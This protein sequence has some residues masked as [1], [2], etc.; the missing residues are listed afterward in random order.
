MPS[1]MELVERVNKGEM[2]DPSLLET[3]LES[4]NSAEKFLAHHARAMLDLRGAHQHMLQSLQAIDYADQKVLNQFV[5]IAGFLGMGD[6]RADPIVKFAASAISR[7]EYALGIEA[8]QNALT[9]DQQHG[10]AWTS[11]RE[12]CL[13]AAGLFERAACA[14][15]WRPETPTDW[16]NKQLRIGWIVSSIADDDVCSRSILSFARHHDSKKCRVHVYSTEALVR[17][18]RQHFA[19]TAYT[20]P[21]AKRGA[22]TL[23]MLGRMKVPCWTAPCDGDSLSASRELAA[24]LASDRID[25]AI[26][27][28][29]LTDPIACLV[30]NWETARARVNLCRRLPMFAEIMD[31]VVYFDPIRHQADHAFWTARNTPA[32]LILEG[33]DLEEA[34]GPVPQR[35]AY[36]IPD[37]AVVLATAG[38]DLDRTIGTEFV[39]CVI[40]ILRAHPHAIY[41][42]I[43][44]GELGWQKR[45]FESAGVGKRVGYAGRRKDMPG[46]LRI[47]DLYLAEFPTAGATQVVQ[48]MAMERPV[49]AIRCGDAIEMSAASE[50]AGPEATVEGGDASAY[51]ERV[52]RLIREPQQRAKLGKSLRSRVEQHYGWNRTARQIEQLCEQLT[53]RLQEQTVETQAA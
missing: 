18:D 26:F 40:N 53:A 31:C 5:S 10:A 48:A 46:F 36:G 42:L 49:V 47:A 30:A 45:R 12:N 14:I 22:N 37:N 9:F 3:Y 11:D 23:E 16:N 19:Q 52:S 51:I 2:I 17:R 50:C 35:N 7:R 34:L 1:L 4:P 33:M 41:L 13:Q 28:T 25:V 27:D 38:S 43:G 6:L 32:Q 29:S 21:S 44:E 20:A 15:N 24:Q 8:I 39:E